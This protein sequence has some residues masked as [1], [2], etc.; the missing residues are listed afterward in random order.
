[1]IKHT[2]QFSNF[3]VFAIVKELNSILLN[4][5]ILNVYEIE[6]LLILKLKTNYGKKNLIIKR[7]S[8]INLTEYDYPIPNY[9]SQ[10]IISLRKLLKNRRI[11]KISQHH[12]DRIVI[13]ELSSQNNTWK[14]IIELFNKGNFLLLDENNTIKIAKK[15]RIFKDR[16]ILA[17]QEYLFPMGQEFNFLSIKKK[18]FKDL[19]INSDI[20]LIRNLSRKLHIS[21]L[22][23]EEICYR[24]NLDKKILSK[25]LSDENLEIL[26]ESFKKV[27]N[28]LLFGEIDA[29]IVIDQ[30]GN[31]I[32]VLPFESEILKKYTKKKF[33]SF[34]IAVDDYFSK[35]DSEALM[36]PKDQRVQELIKN[37]KKILLN[38]QNYLESLKNKKKKYYEQGELIYANLHALDKLIFVISDARKKSYTWEEI[39]NKLHT[40]KIEKIKTSK[41]FDKIIPATN[42]L[43]IKLN[44]YEVYIDLTKSIGENANQIYAKGKKAEKK[45]IGTQVAIKKTQKKINK[46]LLEKESIDLEVDFLLKKPSKKWFEKFRWFTTS[47]NFLII[48]GRDSTSN[49]IIFK[50]HLDPSDLAFHTNFPGSPLVVIKNPDNVEISLNTIEETAIFV[51]SYS[52]AWK[53]NWGVAD[54]FYVN[55]NQISKSPPSGEF[56][57]KGSFII[58]GK[59]NYIKNIK[60]KLAIGLKFVELD[61]NTKENRKV[62]YPKIIAGPKSA[63]H[64]QTNKLISII[65][66]KSPGLSKGKLAKEIKTYFIKNIDKEL[67]KWV[68]LLSIDELLLYLPNGLSNIVK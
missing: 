43:I 54:V 45:I 61:N 24:A 55:S 31:E 26:F 58:S 6:D 19:F 65:P 15:Y 52:R 49:E 51:V 50:K 63:I 35:I 1:M 37:Q 29:H 12:F 36:T 9:P 53:E 57:P 28:Q 13:M 10:Y 16:N 22:Y 46:L 25:N 34:N 23:S 7:D 60:T 39:N 11:L 41:F 33:S 38:Q 5:S 47:D 48:G 44:D 56:L 8:R 27:R 59:K 67:R 66:S 40:A 4:A 32:S 2:R 18:E 68:K 17:N 21:G 20:E 62:F 30:D 3:D 42:Q 14:F 64:T